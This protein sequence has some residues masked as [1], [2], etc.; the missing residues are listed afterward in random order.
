M[1]VLAILLLLVL[2]WFFAQTGAAFIGFLCIVV[3][4]IMALA[5]AFATKPPAQVAQGGAA[6]AAAPSKGGKPGEEEF[7][8]R[9]GEMANFFAYI[10]KGIASWLKTPQKKEEEKKAD[11]TY[12]IRLK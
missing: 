6:P 10:F 11:K 9:I 3:A 12:E 2:A 4:V 5:S 1:S 8:N 7:G